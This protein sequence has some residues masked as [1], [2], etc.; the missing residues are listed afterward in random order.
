MIFNN[1]LK[2]SVLSF[3]IINLTFAQQLPSKASDTIVAQSG[4]NAEEIPIPPSPP[5]PP[6]SDPKLLFYYDTAG[7]QVERI[8]C[9]LCGSSGSSNDDSQKLEEEIFILPEAISVSVDKNI[10]GNA[11]NLFPNPTNGRI[12]IKFLPT[13]N[14]VS[15]TYL[16][17]YN[18][19][20]ALIQEFPVNEFRGQME[21]DLSN[22]PV[23]IYY[24]HFHVSNNESVTKKVIK[25]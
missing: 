19:I 22:Q 11:L 15:I 18:G 5:P 6:Q 2:L 3:L 24:L 21:I 4:K 13:S 17:V 16:S 12:S 8:W 7:N 23:G 25:S 1:Q 14:D 20:G 9:V 10:Y